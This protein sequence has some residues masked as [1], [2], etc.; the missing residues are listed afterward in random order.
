MEKLDLKRL[1]KIGIDRIVISNFKINNFDKLEKKELLEKLTFTKKFSLK[2]ENYNF[3]YCNNTKENGDEYDV[4]FLEFNPTKIMTGLNIYNSNMEE[5]KKSIEFLETSFKENGIDLDLS[6]SKIKEIELNITLP[7]EFQLLNEV[8]NLFG[9]ANKR[10]GLGIYTI[11]P[12]E[13]TIQ[14]MQKLGTFYIN[15][16]R[17]TGKT[18]RIYDKTAE[19]QIK[20][21]IFISEP[22]TR[23]EVLFGRD[24]IREVLEKKGLDNQLNSFLTIKDNELNQ[25]FQDALK[26]ELIINVEKALE[27][28]EKKLISAFNNFRRIERVKRKERKKIIEKGEE[29][30]FYLKQDRG[31]FKYLDKNYWLFDKS[32]LIKMCSLIESRDRGAY[33]KQL[34]KYDHLVNLDIYKIFIKKVFI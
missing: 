6:N 19:L 27:K 22:L 9:K 21:N 20:K 1:S 26:Q 2:D 30:P 32:F 23:V 16:K 14:K 31:V 17:K 3:S 8:I 12:E 33:I 24:F 18:I 7:I 11:D 13:H 25:M 29:V 28:L 34:K 15:S 10:R 4:T 5:L